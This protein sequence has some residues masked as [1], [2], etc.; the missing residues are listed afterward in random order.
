VREEKARRNRRRIL[1]VAHLLF[2]ELGYARTTVSAVADAAGVSDD[3]V[4]HLFR[5][6][7]GLLTEVLNY[8][9]TG[10]PD[11]PVVLDQEG[12]RAVREETDQRRQLAMFAEDMARR[13]S[14]ARPVDDVMRSAAS[15][16][17][18]V[19]RMR[20]RMQRTRLRNLTEFVGWVAERGPLR[21]GVSEEEAAATVWA[22]TSPDM[23]R[24]LV[25]DLGWSDDEY[26]AW[27]DDTLVTKLLPPRVQ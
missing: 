4:F 13:V 15:V 27:L 21:D 1:E 6:K 7:R 20:E 16:D 17:P 24:L 12:P 18:E 5:T 23:H 3:L 14:R 11:S 10:E 19:A 22:L 25:G 9:V 2:L 26:A 8:A